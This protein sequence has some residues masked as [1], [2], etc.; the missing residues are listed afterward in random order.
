MLVREAGQEWL[1]VQLFFDGNIYLE[2]ADHIL[3][4]LVA[5]LVADCLEQGW[6]AGWFF[7]RYFEQGSHLRVRF[8]GRR[9]VLDNQ[10]RARILE[11]V[12]TGSA[13][14]II[15]R[16]E[17]EPY[18]PEAK[19]YAGPH[20]LLR[21]EEWFQASSEAALALLRKVPPGDQPA[22]LGKAMLAMLVMLH[23]FQKDR[24]LAANLAHSYGRNYLSTLV[25]DPQQQQ[26]WFTAFESGFNRQAD[27]LADYVELAW[28]ALAAGQG[29]TEELDF[30]LENTLETAR[31]MRELGAQ[32][33][34]YED[35]EATDDWPRVMLQVVPSY[36]HMMNNRLGVSIQE[37][38]YLSVLIFLTLM[39][40]PQPTC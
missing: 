26:K 38:C 18:E 2:K 35:G 7:I 32:A 25:P 40:L 31:G 30:Y 22:R 19:R 29:L 9:K 33:L 28:E 16:V 6:I 8:L 5:P 4:E 39:G 14:E 23:S 12:A 37:E 11:A 10:V 15:Q 13:S 24:Q 34:L 27:R 17:W 36:L 21:A 20:G 3:L 1:S